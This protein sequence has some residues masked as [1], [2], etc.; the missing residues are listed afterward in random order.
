MKKQDSKKKNA[1]AS[2]KEI[3]EKKRREEGFLPE[4][5]DFY[6]EKK[7]QTRRIWLMC[8]VYF[9]FILMFWV[10]GEKFQNVSVNTTTL[11]CFGGIIYFGWLQRGI[12]N[13]KKVSGIQ[14]NP[15]M[16]VK[17]NIYG[18]RTE[19]SYS[20]IDHVITHGELCYDDTGLKIGYGSRQLCFHYEIGDA[21]AQKHIKECYEILQSHLSVKLPP[22]E[23][24]CLDL[25]DRKY[26][27][28]KSRKKHTLSLL[29]AIMLSLIR[30]NLM[31]IE[32]AKGAV[33]F[34]II[35]GIWENWS[36]YQLF[37]GAVLSA[38]NYDALKSIYGNYPNA[39]YGR[40]NTGYIWFVV[41]V[42]LIIL[43]NL[44]IVL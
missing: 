11:C 27:Y 8:L 35:C 25:L 40:R 23:K 7:R 26:F 6:F 39:R 10:C 18:R 15:N 2:R 16:A 12:L 33:C 13:Q 21:K 31:G 37:K 3:I 29:A 32:T 36:L 41:D 19:I 42:A 34:G 28:E 4:Y 9:T 20:S 5:S 14:L 43:I 1:K 17:T 22:F 30:I 24:K 44:R 38:K